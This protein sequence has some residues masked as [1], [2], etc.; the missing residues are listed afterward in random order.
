MLA[1]ISAL[2]EKVQC[3][4]WVLS[5]GGDLGF[6]AEPGLCLFHAALRVRFCSGP[7]SPLVF[8]A[9]SGLMSWQ[10]AVRVVVK[11]FPWPDSPGVSHLPSC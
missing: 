9:D 2:W 3:I 10:G 11:D 4:G 5:L 7:S 6:T 1:V 8:L